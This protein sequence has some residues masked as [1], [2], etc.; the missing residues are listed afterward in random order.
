M[1]GF[2]CCTDISTAMVSPR[3]K[4]PRESLIWTEINLLEA[5]AEEIVE[6]FELD[7]GSSNE[8]PA[9]EPRI[10]AEEDR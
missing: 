5:R 3:R 8:R 7:S 10:D 6:L 9:I 2:A 4:P 1:I